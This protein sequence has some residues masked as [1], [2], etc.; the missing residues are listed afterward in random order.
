[1]FEILRKKRKEKGIKVSEI[2]SVIGLK[3]KAA[4]YKKESGSVPFTLQESRIISNLF[5]EPIE[6]IFFND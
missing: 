4:Y 3:T 2:C 1:M 5:N 6:N